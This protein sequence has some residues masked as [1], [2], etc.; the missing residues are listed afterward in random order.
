MS[1]QVKS[2]AARTQA[3]RASRAG[4][5]RPVGFQNVTQARQQRMA[6]LRH[7]GTITGVSLRLRSVIV[8]QVLGLVLLLGR[9]ASSKQMQLLVLWHKP[10]SC[11][12]PTEP[13]ERGG[14]GHVRRLNPVAS[15]RPASPPSP[16][17]GHHPAPASPPQT[18]NVR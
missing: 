18:P 2:S 4:G 8:R 15:Q 9:A 11:G 7:P 14:P 1:R 10:L 6:V 5:A 17:F 13:I 3:G 16:H 12:E